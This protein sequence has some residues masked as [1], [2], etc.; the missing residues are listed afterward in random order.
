[1][2]TVLENKNI[3]EMICG[4]ETY[5]WCKD[6]KADYAFAVESESIKER[7]SETHP[8]SLAAKTLSPR[9][10]FILH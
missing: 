4:A 9:T 2:A 6:H 1:M 3:P 8:A 7:V 5:M 10:H